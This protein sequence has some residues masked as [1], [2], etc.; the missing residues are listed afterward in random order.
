MY[1]RFDLRD[2]M[3]L[4]QALVYFVFIGIATIAIAV[5]AH[6]T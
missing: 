3:R 4:A 1:K 5:A 2:E 6:L